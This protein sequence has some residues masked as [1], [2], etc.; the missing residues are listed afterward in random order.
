MPHP[1]VQFRLH[2]LELINHYY[3]M[4]IKYNT[5]RKIKCNLRGLLIWL[6]LQS[7]ESG[8]VAP[9]RGA[10]EG[11]WP[12]RICQNQL[13]VPARTAAE[14]AVTRWNVDWNRDTSPEAYTRHLRNLKG[15]Y[16]VLYDYFKVWT[17]FRLWTIEP[18][19][20]RIMVKQFLTTIRRTLIIRTHG[21]PNAAPRANPHVPKSLFLISTQLTTYVS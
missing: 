16:E 15:I 11:A 14:R 17:C 18:N 20:E 5:E 3:I 19:Q 7:D 1:D 10:F 6:I 13:I 8:I 21:G 2:R 4:T 12:P 9:G